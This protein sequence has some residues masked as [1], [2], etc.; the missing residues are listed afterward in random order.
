MK[1]TVVLM[2]CIIIALTFPCWA[3][4]SPKGDAAEI[5]AF[6]RAAV[7]AFNKKDLEK[8]MDFM[9]PDSPGYK[10]TLM[11]T[12]ELLEKYDVSIELVDYEYIGKTKDYALIRVKQRNKFSKG[13][14]KGTEVEMI[15]ALK[16]HHGAWK[17]WS[18]MQL[19]MK[20]ME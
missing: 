14:Y 10:P 3:G 20:V 6:L 8:N 19:E 4:D 5:Q 9:H 1:E 15:H 12:K 16:K 11:K 7:E 18:L 2:V 17:D 13:P